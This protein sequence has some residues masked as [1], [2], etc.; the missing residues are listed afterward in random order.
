MVYG[1]AAAVSV[2]TILLGR[3]TPLMD[4]NSLIVIL[5]LLVILFANI[6]NDR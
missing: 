5:V 1:T 2:S 4:V 3:R 6:R